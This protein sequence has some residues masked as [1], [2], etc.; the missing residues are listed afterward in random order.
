MAT[1]YFTKFGETTVNT[2]TDAQ[3]QDFLNDGIG[4]NDV[5]FSNI[6]NGMFRQTAAVSWSIAEFIKN[7]LDQNVESGSFDEALLKDALDDWVTLKGF[8]LDSDM[9]FEKS[10][11]IDPSQPLRLKT[12]WGTQAQYDDIVSKDATTLYYVLE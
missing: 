2:L 9:P 7:Q 5:A 8:A 10:P 11:A 12:W 6:L 3:L 1:N 4:F